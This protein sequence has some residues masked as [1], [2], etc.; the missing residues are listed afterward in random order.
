MSLGFAGGFARGG[1]GLFAIFALG[2]VAIAS[3]FQKARGGR[4]NATTAA[5]PLGA[6]PFGGGRALIECGFAATN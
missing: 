6:G 5:E 4:Q 2:F 3:E 1:A